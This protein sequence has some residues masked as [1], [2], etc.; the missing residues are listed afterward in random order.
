MLLFVSGSEQTFPSSRSASPFPPAPDL[1]VS[2]SYESLSH[3]FGHPP[4]TR[5]Q[6]YRQRKSRP[7]GPA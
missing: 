3:R 6:P 5:R 1:T 7:I 4:T 2:A